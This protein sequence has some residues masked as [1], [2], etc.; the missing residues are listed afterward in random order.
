M[1]ERKKPWYILHLSVWSLKFKVREANALEFER[2]PS[3]RMDDYHDLTRAEVRERVMTRVLDVMPQC[4]FLAYVA[5]EHCPL[6][7][8]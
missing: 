2:D 6:Y 7:R 8:N 1:E 5:S 4:P 3:F